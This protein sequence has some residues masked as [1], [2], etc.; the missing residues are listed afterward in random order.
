MHNDC[1]WSGIRKAKKEDTGFKKKSVCVSNKF[2]N[3]TENL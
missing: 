2:E 1:V 3:L